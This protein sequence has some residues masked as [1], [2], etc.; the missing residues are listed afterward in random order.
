MDLIS[1]I[2]GGRGCYVRE[3][4]IC[5]NVGQNGGNGTIA[6]DSTEKAI[7][8]KRKQLIGVWTVKTGFSLEKVE[9]IMNYSSFLT[10]NYWFPILRQVG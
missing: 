4:A 2:E 5:E 6:L 3:V 8:G 1:L 7:E 10:F 9:Q